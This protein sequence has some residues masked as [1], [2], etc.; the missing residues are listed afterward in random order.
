MNVVSPLNYSAKTDETITFTFTKSR[1]NLNV[2]VSLDGAVPFQAA[3]TSFSF[4]MAGAP[5][6][7]RV[8]VTGME[9]DNCVISIKGN[10]DGT[11]DGDAIVLT[12]LPSGLKTYRFVVGA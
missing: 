9:N 7:L 1:P 12:S 11:T 6:N 3:D 4:D 5:H 10:K 8:Q 2:G